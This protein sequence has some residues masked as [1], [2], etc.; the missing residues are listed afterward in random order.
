V[1][2]YVWRSWVQEWGRAED[3][4]GT[5]GY[6]SGLSRA[7]VCFYLSGVNCKAWVSRG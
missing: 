2:R 5:S 6:E 4:D 3:H 7:S 1:V